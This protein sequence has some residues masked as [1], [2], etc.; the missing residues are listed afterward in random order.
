[1]SDLTTPAFIAA[2]TRLVSRRGLPSDI[3][4]D[5]GTNFVGARN[6]MAELTNLVQSDSHHTA[7]A[8]FL[9]VQGIQFHFNP[10]YAPHQGGY[11]KAGVKSMKHHL[12]R[13]VED[14]KLSIEE[15][16]TLLS[17]VEA[18]LNSRPLTPSSSDPN[19]FGVLTPGHFLTGQ[20]LKP[21]PQEDL[22]DVH[23]NRLTSWQVLESIPFV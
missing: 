1:V 6:E 18:A 21:V 15:F 12:K 13:V 14:R 23:V 10:P 11:W 2:L 20:N 17:Q 9:N 16:I 22:T 4:C 3:F 8:D 5:G 19:D 7:V